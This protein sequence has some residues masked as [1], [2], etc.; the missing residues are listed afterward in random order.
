MLVRFL[1]LLLAAALFAQAQLNDGDAHGDAPYL[2]EQG[3]TP[4][5]NGHDLSGWHGLG[6]PN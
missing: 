4:L 5:F 3:W 2:V 6:Q 1:P